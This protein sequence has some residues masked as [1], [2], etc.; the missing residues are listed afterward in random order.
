MGKVA[1]YSG[2]SDTCLKYL[3]EGGVTPT[4]IKDLSGRGYNAAFTTAP[5]PLLVNGKW[6]Y[7]FV[8][9]S[10]EYC[11]VPDIVPLLGATAATWCAYVRKDAYVNQASIMCDYLYGTANALKWQFGFE[12]SE[13]NWRC[14]AGDGTTATTLEIAGAYTT[15][16]HFVWCRFT[17]GSATG[18]ETGCDN[19]VAT[20]V[21]TASIA[22]LGSTAQNRTF[23]GLYNYGPYY[24]SQTLGALTIW[25]SAITDAEI[26]K[27]RWDMKAK[28]GL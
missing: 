1:L 23:I 4:L 19:S 28:L 10:S 26:A 25:P 20:P 16:W 6:C 8:S 15:G 2:G 7:Q 12:N 13:N 14:R 24:S 21:T 17:G 3:P 18:L 11:L 22:A 27:W 9:G 5:E